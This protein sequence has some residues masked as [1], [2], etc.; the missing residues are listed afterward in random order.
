MQTE[1]TDEAAITFSD[2]LYTALAQGFP[3]DAALAQARRAIF[4]AGR[5]V[6]FGTPVLFMRVA[7]GRI[8][9]VTGAPPPPPVG[10]LEAKLRAGAGRGPAGRDASPGSSRCGTPASRRCPT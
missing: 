8:F 1:I 10:R 7:D 3:I 9:D 5:E 2:R 6:E 4:A